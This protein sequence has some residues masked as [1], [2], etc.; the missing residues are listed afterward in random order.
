MGKIRASLADVSTEFKPI[1]PGIYNFE[2][3][4]VE[5]VEREGNL[6]AYRVVS[7]VTDDGESQNRQMSDYIAIVKRD[8]ELNEI[9]LSTLKRYFE[10]THGKD[11]V[12]DWTD[13]DYDTDL[14]QGKQF[15]GQVVIDS[16]TKDGETEPR[17]TNKFKR[18]ESLA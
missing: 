1:E 10:V 9:G 2:I 5:E 14:L 12:A 3:D 8:G 16:Y 6:V 15:K 17:Q 13:D 11:E 4:K 7:K 18:I